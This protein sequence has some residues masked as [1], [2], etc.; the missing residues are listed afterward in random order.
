MNPI[1]RLQPTPILIYI[2]IRPF[3][4]RESKSIMIHIPP[5][6]WLGENECFLLI[7][8]LRSMRRGEAIEGK[9]RMSVGRRR[10]GLEFQEE[11]RR[12]QAVVWR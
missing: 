5:Y 1:L 2:L 11:Y 8:R 12:R 4:K 10:S 6:S 7:S 3:H 9:A